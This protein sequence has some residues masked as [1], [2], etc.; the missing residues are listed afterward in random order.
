RLVTKIISSIPA[1]TASSTI[2]CK[3]GLS[4]MGS[5]SLGTTLVAGSIRVPR[6]A[7]GKTALRIRIDPPKKNDRKWHPLHFY[8]YITI[9]M[10]FTI[11]VNEKRAIK[12]STATPS[13]VVH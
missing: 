6:P 11:E 13:V 5:S 8:N 3:I 2:Y 10:L 1:A 7:I 12:S 4:T 9:V